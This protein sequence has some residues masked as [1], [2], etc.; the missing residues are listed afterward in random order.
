MREFYVDGVYMP[1]LYVE[2]IVFYRHIK[3]SCR[4]NAVSSTY[5]SHMSMRCTYQV[6]MSKLSPFIDILDS[7]VEI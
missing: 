1:D 2:I 4:N 5:K 6:Y 3:L 7:H